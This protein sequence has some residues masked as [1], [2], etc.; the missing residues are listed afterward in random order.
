MVM[1]GLSRHCLAAP[2]DA[3]VSGVVRDAHGIPQ[4]GA[5][6]QL[7]AADATTI[8]TAFTDDHGRYIIPAVIPG[9][10][11]LRATAAF[12][13]P[14]VRGNVRLQA[15]AQAIVNLTMTTLF[16][17]ETWLPAQKRRVGEPEDDWKWTLRSTANRPLLRIVDPSSSLQVSSSAENTHHA[18]SQ[19]RVSVSSNDGAFA[20]GGI[21]QVLILNSTTEDGDSAILRADLGNPPAGFPLGNSLEVSGGYEHSSPLGGATRLVSSYQSHPELAYGAGNGVQVLQ[22][23]STQELRFGDA[24]VIDAGTLMK[25]ER[26]ASTHLM[27]EPFVRVSVRPVSGTMVEYRF[28][29]GR[30]LQSSEDLDRIKPQTDVVTDTAGHVL[31]TANS[32]NEIGVSKKLGSRTLA[33]SA[34]QDHFDNGVIAGT[35]QMNA[36]TLQQSDVIADAA[37][38]AFRLRTNSYSARG[39]GVSFVQPITPSLAAWMEYD[40]GS[41][42]SLK[43]GTNGTPLSSVS[44]SVGTHTS[45][46]AGVALR[47]KILR[48]GT[49]LRAEYRWQP[50]NTLSQVNAYNANPDEAYLGMLLRQRIWFGRLLPDGIDA[51]VEATNLLEQGY[52]PVLSADGHTLYLA[53]VPR[54]IQAGL[55]FNF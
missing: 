17:A 50:T 7:L 11:E 12:L 30:T 6:V 34:Y 31:R 33:V 52:Q 38:N 43:P 46:A 19:A 18:S 16:E 36:A 10:Y 15:G 26:L 1:L 29:T 5:L 51:V 45:H 13:L 23:A 28:A 22:M 47:G 49:S 42:L 24:V 20:Q 39:L 55:S 53:Q 35:G 14:T 2:G 25:A 32:H 37:T 8:A 9:K 4:M 54:T 21:H 27:N 48:S 40:L 41:A 3:N 44:Q